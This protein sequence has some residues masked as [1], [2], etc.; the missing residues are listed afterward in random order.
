MI[1]D[2]ES[3]FYIPDYDINQIGNYD[4]SEGYMMFSIYDETVGMNMAGQPINHDHPIVLEPYKVNMVPYFHDDCLPVEYAFSS[5]VNE[6][7]LVK[8][9]DGRFYIPDADINTLNYVCPG[10]AY[11]VFIDIDYDITFHYPEMLLG[12]QSV[13]NDDVLY[14]E[15]LLESH[16][17][18][19]TGI[20]C[21]LY[22]SPSPRD[23]LL[24]R[25]P[26]SA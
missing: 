11:I 23:G 5:I 24:S 3:N 16:D 18:Y 7:L 19:K 15:S 20:A 8:D 10:N 1:F 21:L 14:H 2:D 17:I 22:T 26:S 4:Y 12:K 13:S 6:L 25:M 9:D